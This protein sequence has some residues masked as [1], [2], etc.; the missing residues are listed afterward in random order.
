MTAKDVPYVFLIINFMVVT[1]FAGRHSVRVPSPAVQAAI[2]ISTAAAPIST[3][4]P[5]ADQGADREQVVPA[6]PLPPVVTVEALPERSLVKPA[7]KAVDAKPL[8]T[9]SAVASVPSAKIEL[10][11]DPTAVENPYKRKSIGSGP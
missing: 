1:F 6:E 7:S 11:E 9:A 10:E 2:P 3:S 8:T 5:V 4:R